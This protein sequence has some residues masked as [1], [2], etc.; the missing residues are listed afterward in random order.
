M[1]ER[2]PLRP[3]RESEVFRFHMHASQVRYYGA[4]SYFFDGTPAEVFL[5]AGKV[6]SDVQAVA[7]D[8]AIAASLALQFGCPAETLRAALTRLDDHKA[9]GPLGE[10]LDRVLEVKA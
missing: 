4:V 8:A 2:I 7:R 3:R 9:A 6:G 10:L 5:D 1:T